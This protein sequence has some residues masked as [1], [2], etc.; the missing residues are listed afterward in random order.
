MRIDV[1][2]E[3]KLLCLG[4]NH[5]SE[6]E[7][8]LRKL[9]KS[10]SPP[11]PKNLGL[12]FFNK[13]G[14]GSILHVQAKKPVET[15]AKQNG[16]PENIPAGFYLGNTIRSSSELR[17]RL[18]TSNGDAT[19]SKI[20]TVSST[21]QTNSGEKAG[22]SLLPKEIREKMRVRCRRAKKSSSA[23]TLL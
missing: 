15:K 8:N 19:R 3:Y 6:K 17:Q 18:N 23:T 20:L 9:E 2:K 16:G 7:K 10:L 11:K 14:S 21:A 1:I 4:K 13:I 5:L 12:F 22:G